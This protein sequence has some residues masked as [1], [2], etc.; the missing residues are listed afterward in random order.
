LFNKENKNTLQLKMQV[1][2][3]IN[4]VNISH[5]PMITSWNR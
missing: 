5:E 4:A 1:M 2:R 3:Q